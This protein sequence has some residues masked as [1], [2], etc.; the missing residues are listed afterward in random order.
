MDAMSGTAI[1]RTISI[2]LD[3]PDLNPEGTTR[4]KRIMRRL[5]IIAGLSAALLT[6]AGTAAIAGLPPH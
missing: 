2:E 1:S 6:A 4:M 3:N 5:A